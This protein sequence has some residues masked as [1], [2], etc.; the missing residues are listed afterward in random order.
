M[1]KNLRREGG[2]GDHDRKSFLAV[3]VERKGRAA[4]HRQKGA[5]FSPIFRRRENEKK[6][7]KGGLLL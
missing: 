2:A 4:A 5:I 1:Q 6:A 3:A 7:A